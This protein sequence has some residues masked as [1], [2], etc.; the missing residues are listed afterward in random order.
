MS[1]NIEQ[2][3]IELSLNT[4]QQPV[5]LKSS[6]LELSDLKKKPV[7]LNEYPYFTIDVE[8]PKNKLYSLQ[9]EDLLLFFFN[10]KSNPNTYHNPCKPK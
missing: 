10:I 9:S 7:G 5:T 4:G 6:M 8:Y 2:I 3:K 1:F